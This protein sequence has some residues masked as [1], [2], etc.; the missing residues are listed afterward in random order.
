MTSIDCGSTPPV[1]AAGDD[2]T[3]A[4]GRELFLA[5]RNTTV[6][7]SLSS[8]VAVLTMPGYLLENGLTAA[9]ISNLRARLIG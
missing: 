7:A 1:S 4:R 6:E 9:E 2:P 8:T 3:A 5:T